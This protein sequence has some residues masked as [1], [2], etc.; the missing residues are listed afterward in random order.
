MK[1]KET[2]IHRSVDAGVNY[3]SAIAKIINVEPGE[4]TSDTVDSTEY[5]ASHDYKE[6]DYGLKD[7]G[8][9]NITIRYA[10]GQTDV[11]AFIDSYANSTKEFIE[12]Q[13]PAPISKYKRFRCLV[14]KVGLATPKEGQIDRMLT[15]KVDGE[16]TN[17]D[18]S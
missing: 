15:L 6:Y 3:G 11:E 5:G 10:A 13:F 8:E 12:V 17:G 9:W 2:T 14:T 1:G 16:P 7:G 18:L 4:E